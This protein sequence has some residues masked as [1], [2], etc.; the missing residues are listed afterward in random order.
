MVVG[1]GVWTDRASR[2]LD[3]Q[4]ELFPV[5]ACAF[6]KGGVTLVALEGAGQTTLDVGELTTDVYVDVVTVMN[7]A[8]EGDVIVEGFTLTGAR[9]PEGSAAAVLNSD[10]VT[11][12][13]CRFVGNG[14]LNPVSS[15]GEVLE[16]EDASLELI[17]CE[18]TENA[19]EIMMFFVDAELRM[20]RCRFFGNS[21]QCLKVEQ[22][23][24]FVPV[25]VEDCE[26]RE[27][28]SLGYGSA[29]ALGR[30][31]DFEIRGS[32]IRSKCGRDLP[33]CRNQCPAKYGR[34]RIQRLRL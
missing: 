31:P 26:F 14:P 27:C 34:H 1:P 3:F 24:S 9:N 30:V 2:L 11:F 21:G 13:S 16:G 33:G 20:T 18:V 25:Y 7:Q 22:V 17:D 6:P 5:T 28:R 23:S 4:G 32:P 8:G 19:G 29:I 10:K 15:G 12:R